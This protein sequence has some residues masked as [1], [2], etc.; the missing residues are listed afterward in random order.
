[1]IM[2]AADAVANCGLES[3]KLWIEF[4]GNVLGGAAVL[5]GGALWLWLLLR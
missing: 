5:G 2:L 3:T 1:M 4:F